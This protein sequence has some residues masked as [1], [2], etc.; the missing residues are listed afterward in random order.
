MR[1]LAA[2]ASALLLVLAGCSKDDSDDD[3]PPPITAVIDTPAAN[4]SILVGDSVSFTGHGADGREPYTYLWTFPGG[5][6]GSSTEEDPAAP[7]Q[8]NTAGVY[9]VT[10]KATDADGRTGYDSVTVS[11]YKILDHITLTPVDPDL[12]QGSTLD[13]TVTAY[14]TDATSLNVTSSALY[15]NGDTTR[16]RMTNNRALALVG[17]TLTDVMI[18]ADYTHGVA[19]NDGTDTSTISTQDPVVRWT[20][21][22]ILTRWNQLAAVETTVSY[23][24]GEEPSMTVNGFTGDEGQLKPQMITDGINRANMYRYLAGLPNGLTETTAETVHCQKGAHV[25][26]MLELQGY[27]TYDRHNPFRPDGVAIG[28]LYDVNI[29]IPGEKACGESNIMWG[30]F[31]GTDYSYVPTLPECVD[32]W[33]DDFGNATTLGHR[34]WILYPE[35]NTTTF[36][37]IWASHGASVHTHYTCL[38]YVWDDSATTPSYDYVAYPSEGYYPKQCFEDPD[39]GQPVLWSFSVNSDLYDL[40]SLTSVTVVRQSDNATLPITTTVLLPNY[41]ITPTISFNP[42]ES[43]VGETYYVTINNIRLKSNSSR[44]S[45]SYWVSFYNMF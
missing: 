37:M 33:M 7:V 34:R 16:V 10:L 2:A 24:T 31:T 20:K 19:G 40:D 18:T 12:A 8:F 22:Q 6:P 23:V 5:T 43:T 11:V 3:G 45:Y 39:D 44:F 32:G 35:L 21:A 17:P 25:L 1:F 15:T 14:F 9:N 28:S 41:G 26:D 4:V 30:S 27:T 13:F 42:N 38:M 29:Y 36:G